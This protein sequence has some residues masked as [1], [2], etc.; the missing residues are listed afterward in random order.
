M[1]MK[2][3]VT[4]AI[5][6]ICAGFERDENYYTSEN[7]TIVDFFVR[8]MDLSDYKVPAVDHLGFISNKFFQKIE[9][10]KAIALCFLVDY[11]KN[12]SPKVL[13]VHPPFDFSGY[14]VSKK[15]QKSSTEFIRALENFELWAL[16]SKFLN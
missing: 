7:E 15:C 11:I 4:V 3:L 14:R 6:N 1:L 8:T 9:V 10:I 13:Q 2:A 12:L 16:K 5:V